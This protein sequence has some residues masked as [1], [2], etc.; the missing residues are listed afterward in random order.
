MSVKKH[1]IL[2]TS[3]ANKN[4]TNLWDMNEERTTLKKNLS[5]NIK[6]VTCVLV[7]NERYKEVEENDEFTPIKHKRILVGQRDETIKA[8]DWLDEKC[9]TIL[10]GHH[11]KIFCMKMLNQT[12]FSGQFSSLLASGSEDR[13]IKVWSLDESSSLLVVGFWNFF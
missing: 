1:K 12:H 13:T 2:L 6:G 4:A 9:L 11:G 5:T 3:S 8:F 10:N 7:Y